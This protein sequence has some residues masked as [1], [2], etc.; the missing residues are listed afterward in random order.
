MDNDTHLYHSI[1]QSWEICRNNN[2]SID[3]QKPALELKDSEF[4]SY[5]QKKTF[6]RG[7]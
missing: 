5:T 1:L 6:N 2:V 7:I 3:L 4:K